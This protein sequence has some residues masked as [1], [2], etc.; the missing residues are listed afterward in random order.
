MQMLM[1]A[2]TYIWTSAYLHH[3]CHRCLK[4][5]LLSPISREGLGKQRGRV[6][7]ARTGTRT[8]DT[9][10]AMAPTTTWRAPLVDELL[11]DT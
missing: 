3:T 11:F 5:D 4:C 9:P 2:Y 8:W 7:Q 10:A 6:T 1:S